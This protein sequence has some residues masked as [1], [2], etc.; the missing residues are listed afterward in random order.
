MKKLPKKVFKGRFFFKNWLTPEIKTQMK[1][2]DKKRELARNS[3]DK[4]HWQEYR[5]EKN[6]CSKN[7]QKTKN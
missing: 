1:L 7:L 2:R 6:S 5:R 3:R 4:S